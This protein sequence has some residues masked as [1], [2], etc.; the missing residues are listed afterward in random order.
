ML[1]VVIFV[2]LHKLQS[3]DSDFF[4]GEP[5]IECDPDW[6]DSETYSPP[7]KIK[8]CKRATAYY[9]RLSRTELMANMSK[10]RSFCLKAELE[11]MGISTRGLWTNREL[12]DVY[13]GKTV[14]SARP[15]EESRKRPRDEGSA[16]GTLGGAA[17]SPPA[18]VRAA[19][20]ALGGSAPG[21]ECV[22]LWGRCWSQLR[23]K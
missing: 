4:F 21:S 2:V 9:A 23:Y 12:V 7:R 22:M 14:S 6:P 18:A 1:G 11:K 15:R 19:E 20:P 10:T 16:L 13:L 17:A 3:L 8:G 5:I